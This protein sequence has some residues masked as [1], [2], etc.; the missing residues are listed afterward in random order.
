MSSAG[1]LFP[2]LRPLLEHSCSLP[3]K[4]PYSWPV[5]DGRQK[6]LACLDETATGIQKA[7]KSG[8]VFRPLLDFEKVTLVGVK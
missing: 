6:N 3:K 5:V 4:Q 1:P 8:A 2:V 7:I